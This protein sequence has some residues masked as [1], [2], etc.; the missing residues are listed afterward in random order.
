MM[1]D[2]EKWGQTSFTIRVM[3]IH[4]YKTEGV[5]E[6]EVDGVLNEVYEDDQDSWATPVLLMRLFSL[7]FEGDP[8]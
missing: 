5:S 6:F 1:F 4:F 8:A 7:G 2:F 3:G